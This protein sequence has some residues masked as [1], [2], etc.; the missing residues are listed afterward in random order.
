MADIMNFSLNVIAWNADKMAND[1]T[2]L[3][4]QEIEPEILGAEPGCVWKCFL[5][6][7]ST[8]LPFQWRHPTERRGE[9]GSMLPLIQTAS[10]SEY[11]PKAAYHKYN[12]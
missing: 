1:V 3:L 2:V 10:G 9:M 12:F 7:S 6:N 8:V 11:D 5:T 4:L